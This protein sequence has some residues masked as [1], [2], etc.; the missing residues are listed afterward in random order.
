M[1][2]LNRNWKCW[3]WVIIGRMEGIA[4]RKFGQMYE[5]GYIDIGRQSMEDCDREKLTSIVGQFN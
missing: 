2:K 5:K 3:A 1:K 4:V